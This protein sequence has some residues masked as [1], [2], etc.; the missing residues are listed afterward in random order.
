[1]PQLA[2]GVLRYMDEFRLN[3]ATSCSHNAIYVHHYCFM[4]KWKILKSYLKS[5]FFVPFLS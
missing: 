1:M 5:V 3:D 4:D 2:A